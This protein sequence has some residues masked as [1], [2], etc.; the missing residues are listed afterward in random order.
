M[1]TASKS[2]KRLLVLLAAGVGI[3][4]MLVDL[5]SIRRSD[6]VDRTMLKMAG[7]SRKLE[8]NAVRTKESIHVEEK[9]TIPSNDNINFDSPSHLTHLTAAGQIDWSRYDHVYYYHTRKAGGTSFASWVSALAKKNNKTY[10]RDEG[11]VVEGMAKAKKGRVLRVTSLRDPVERAI[12]SFNFDEH[13]RSHGTSNAT[14]SEFILR[15]AYMNEKKKPSK[16]DKRLQ[17]NRGWIWSC[18]ANCYSKW[19][20]GVW[21][22]VDCIP[23]VAAAVSVLND[24][25]IILFDNI[26]DDTYMQ[27]LYERFNATDI[28]IRHKRATPQKQKRTVTKTEKKILKYLNEKDLELFHAMSTKWNKLWNQTSTSIV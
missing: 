5:M 7:T 10:S 17:M 13:Q 14:L 4:N 11:F 28:P 6:A 19:F 9:A 22:T 20:G 25:E 23:N 26:K 16:Y 8:T 24:F 12:S 1:G 18:A 21:P 2:A 3:H 15:S 27:W